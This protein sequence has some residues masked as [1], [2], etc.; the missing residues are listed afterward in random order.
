MSEI[1][2][3]TSTDIQSFIPTEVQEASISLISA[4]AGKALAIKQRNFEAIEKAEIVIL[5][6]QRIIADEYSK[7][8]ANGKLT[9]NGVRCKDWC[10]ALGTSQQTVHKWKEKLLD[11]KKYQACIESVQKKTRQMISMEQDGKNH[12]SGGN[13]DWYTPEAYIEA[14]RAVLDGIDCDPASSDT[15]QYVVNADVYF[16]ENDNGL[17]KA[18]HGS[19]WLNPPYSMPEI[20]LFVDK[21]ISNRAVDD[22]IVLT[23]N[24]SDTGWFHSLL[25]CADVTCFTKGRIGFENLDGE[26]MATRQGQTFF[27]KGDN[28]ELFISEFKKFGAILDVVHVHQA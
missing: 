25:E 9:Q 23:N 5:K 22:W 14:A 13:N 2:A 16:T 24:S 15:A 10:K 21:L 17:N 11:E 28:P 12:V 18:W 3:K 8:F 19:V 6:Q 7:S 20:Q 26:V 27:Y 1:A 4:R